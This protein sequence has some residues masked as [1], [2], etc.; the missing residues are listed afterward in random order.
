MMDVRGVFISW[1]TLVISS[2]LKCS[3][4]IR[5]FTALFMPSPMR[6]SCSPCSFRGPRIFAVSTR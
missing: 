5:S 6:F 3:D 2:V 1:E 4:R